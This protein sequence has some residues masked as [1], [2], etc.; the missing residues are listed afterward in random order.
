MSIRSGKGDNGFTELSFRKNISKDSIDIQ[1]IGDLDELNSYLGF[2]KCKL[3][4][5]KDKTVLEK[6][7]Q[8]ISKI[9]SEITVG[10][11][12]KKKLGTLLKKEDADWAKNKVY[13]LE[14]TTSVTDHFYVPGNTEISALLD[15]ARSVAR[16][17][18]R[19]IVSLF[20]KESL[21]NEN[22]LC[23]MNCISDILFIM[24]RE[25]SSKKSRF[26]HR[27]KRKIK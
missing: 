1:V 24:A 2:I 8:A 26:Y 7:Q 16:R 5:N 23:Y 11:E 6:I 25:K 17:A 9:A 14:E 3:R 27:R 22:V 4:A 12:K 15:V 18:E 19:S 13:H 20:K 10:G 21:K